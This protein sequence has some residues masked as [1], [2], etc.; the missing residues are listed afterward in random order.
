[1]VWRSNI[2]KPWF[3]VTFKILSIDTFVGLKVI[4]QTF[5]RIFVSPNLLRALINVLF[6]SALNYHP[7][8]K[9]AQPDYEEMEF[10][11]KLSGDML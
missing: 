11:S 10:L 2:V 3:F 4:W 9:I 5:L 7:E 1:M 6:E 8:T